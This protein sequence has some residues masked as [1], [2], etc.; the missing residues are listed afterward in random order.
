MTVATAKNFEELPLTLTVYEVADL[1][2]VS[3][4]VA[5]ALT[6]Q[7][8]FPAVRVGERRLV[9]PRDRFLKWLNE[10]ADEPIL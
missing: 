7:R 6:K 4:R 10:S 2:N 5:Y 1:L 8:G 3:L 9:I